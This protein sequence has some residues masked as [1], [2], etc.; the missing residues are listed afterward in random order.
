MPEDRR[1]RRE[2]R[3]SAW[4][5]PRG[6]RHLADGGHTHRWPP[7][8]ARSGR[9][10]GGSVADGASCVHSARHTS[11]SPSRQASAAFGVMDRWIRWKARG[12]WSLWHRVAGPSRYVRMPRPGTHRSEEIE[13]VLPSAPLSARGTSLVGAPRF[14]GRITNRTTTCGFLIPRLEA[15]EEWVVGL[16]PLPRCI[17]CVHGWVVDTTPPRGAPPSQGGGRRRPITIPTRKKPPTLHA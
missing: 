9:V 2:A 11:V 6:G 7:S 3:A 16:P 4:L 14:V 8:A 17:W 5:C 13:L 10:F 1:A 12:E 15:L